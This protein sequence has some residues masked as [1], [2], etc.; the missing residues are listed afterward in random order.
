MK[1]TVDRQRCI[2]AGMCLL[3]APAAFDQDEDD[4][5]VVLLDAEPSPGLHGPVRE[6][7]ENCPA[8][9]IATDDR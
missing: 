2:G 4:G 9:A 5:P 1:I 6:A 3:T 7:V 8:A